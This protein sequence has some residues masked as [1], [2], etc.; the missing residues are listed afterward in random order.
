MDIHYYKKQFLVLADNRSLVLA[1]GS[2]TLCVI[3]KMTI[4]GVG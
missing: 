4:F 3:Q 2:D 1:T